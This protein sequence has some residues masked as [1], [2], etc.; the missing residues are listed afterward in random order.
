MSAALKLLCYIWAFRIKFWVPA[1]IWP[2]Q[3][4]THNEA[5]YFEMGTE[6]QWAHIKSE[7]C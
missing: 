1:Y 3:A 7:N 5:L 2:L 6:I 4:D